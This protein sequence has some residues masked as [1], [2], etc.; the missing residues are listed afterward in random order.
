MKA[1]VTLILPLGILL[2]QLCE[3]LELKL[4][5]AE[6]CSVEANDQDD[7]ATAIEHLAV[8]DSEGNHVSVVCQRSPSEDWCF[9]LKVDKPGQVRRLELLDKTQN[10]LKSLSFNLSRIIRDINVNGEAPIALSVGSDGKILATASSGCESCTVGG[11]ETETL[12]LEQLGQT[13]PLIQE[14][15]LKDDIVFTA[16]TIFILF[17]CFPETLLEM[18]KTMGNAF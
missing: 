7:Q 2:V 1:L 18:M 4:C 9:L 16:V 5:L 12:A 6:K 14:P 3:A 13:Q 10:V 15:M 17:L 8:K 11:G